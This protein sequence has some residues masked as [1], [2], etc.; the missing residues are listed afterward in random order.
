MAYDNYEQ[1]LEKFRK[2][3][4]KRATGANVSDSC[5]EVGWVPSQYYHFGNDNDLF[6][7]KKTKI[8][9][10]K[11]KHGPKTKQ[12]SHTIVVPHSGNDEVIF[13]KCSSQQL[14]AL[15]MVLRG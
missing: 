10:V 12:I 9:A 6:T 3:T 2:V 1:K 14:E 13:L 4:N 7:E 15:K 5:A 11:L 8:S